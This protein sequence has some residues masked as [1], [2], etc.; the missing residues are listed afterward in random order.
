[1]EHKKAATKESGLDAGVTVAAEL[2]D[3][4]F[5]LVLDKI[6]LLREC[7]YEKTQL[8]LAAAYHHIFS[9]KVLGF[10]MIV[11]IQGLYMWLS[12]VWAIHECGANEK[13][14]MVNQ[15]LID[16]DKPILRFL[17]YTDKLKATDPEFRIPRIQDDGT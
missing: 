1:L 12:E 10:E 5:I 3:A 11:R 9:M 13:L 17:F 8:F 16:A 14:E 6:S 7:D 2:G 4:Y 15:K